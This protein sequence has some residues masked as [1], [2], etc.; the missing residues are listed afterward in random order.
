MTFVFA[1]TQGMHL[2]AAGTED[3]AADTVYVRLQG[4]AAGAIVVP[5]GMDQVSATNAAAIR[6]YMS[7]VAS[8]LAAGAGSQDVYGAS[9]SDAATAYGLTDELNAAGL[10]G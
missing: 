6:T 3:L 5:P 4:D 2:A 7:G 10:G 8:Q 1:E 9:I